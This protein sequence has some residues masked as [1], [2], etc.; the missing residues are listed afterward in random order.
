MVKVL[1]PSSITVAS[2]VT[3]TLAAL[4]QLR[5]NEI[6][7]FRDNACIGNPDAIHDMRVS[8]RRLQ[9]LFKTFKVYFH[10]KRIKK[11]RSALCKHITALGE[12][13]ECDVLIEH[14]TWGTAYVPEYSEATLSLLL[15]RI[16]SRRNTAQQ[17]L[18]A[19]I[20]DVKT[21]VLLSDTARNIKHALTSPK[22][23]PLSLG[24]FIRGTIP[25]LFEEFLTAGNMVINHPLRKAA[26]HK[27]RIQGKPLRY[28]MECVESCFNADF[29]ACYKEVKSVISL[30]GDIHDNDVAIDMLKSWLLE[31]RDFN[32]A[33][34]M[35]GR[36]TSM[37]TGFLS[38]AI[39][40]I[41]LQRKERFVRLETIFNQCKSPQF[42]A[43][44]V[45]AMTS[46]PNVH[47]PH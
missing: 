44:L 23:Q 33:A 26:L 46:L 22:K 20:N 35:T 42:S 24:D 10:K 39:S 6:E 7:T 16:T 4:I 15:G 38:T 31:I 45:A 47:A 8:C 29:K 12:V 13:R 17:N 11:I 14:I 37:H 30:L 5:L 36:K 28:C 43:T 1:T 3:D 19:L 21:L 2:P 18:T 9:A 41:S 27:L 40:T 34:K 32:R 25:V